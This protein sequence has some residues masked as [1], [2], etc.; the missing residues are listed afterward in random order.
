MACAN[1]WAFHE[2]MMPNKVLIS[3]WILNQKVYFI[4]YAQNG[5]YISE[6]FILEIIKYLTFIEDIVS[7]IY[8]HIICHDLF[9]FP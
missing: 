9:L 3:L 4:I 5:K 7:G 6:D 2:L 1:V 8:K